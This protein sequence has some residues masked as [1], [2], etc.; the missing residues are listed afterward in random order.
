MSVGRGAGECPPA[1]PAAQGVLDEEQGAVGIMLE[2]MWLPPSALPLSLLP[3][4]P[5]RPPACP[6]PLLQPYRIAFDRVA[7]G[8]I[9][10]QCVYVL[11][12]T[13]AATMQVGG[14]MRG[15][16]DAWMRGWV[17]GWV[18]HQL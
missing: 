10:H 11:C 18:Q 4:K 2:V 17:G 16:V 14:W 3:P 7:C 9:F 8:A 13:E 5:A 12:A 6:L 1:G 15:C